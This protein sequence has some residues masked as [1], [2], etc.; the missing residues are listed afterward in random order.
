M[1]VVALASVSGAPGVTTAAIAAAV[2]WPR[3]VL[4]VEADTSNVGS[5]M[6]GFFRSNLDSAAG[7]HQV[8]VALSR[9]ALNLNALLD[10]AF[11]ISIAVHELPPI[12]TMPIPS[13]PA[14]HRMWAIPGY[15]DLQIIDGVRAVWDRLPALLAQAHELG[16]DV[17]VDLGRLQR[18]EPRLQ[19]LDGADQVV[20]VAT[21]TMTDLNRLHRRLRLPDLEERLEGLGVS[22]YSALVV[23]A[24]AESVSP[25][26]FAR[27]TLPV[28]GALS[29]DP[30]GAA[31]FALGREDRRPARNQYRADIRG[32]VSAL[33]ERLRADQ[34]S[35]RKAS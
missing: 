17:I 26:D 13:L 10:P 22:K 12:P 19:L 27:S 20:L 7:M 16:I 34:N 3:P 28:V 30:E 24:T 11:G 32:V 21:T 6:T 9:Q 25:S 2:H 4:L 8:S 15:R 35:D 33:D 1:S 29:F 14:G 5:L 18:D 23:K 31:V